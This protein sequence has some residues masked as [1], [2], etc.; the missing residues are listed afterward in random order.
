M[1]EERLV[2]N[3]KQRVILLRQYTGPE[4]RK[5]CLSFSRTAMVEI[6][7]KVGIVYIYQ[8]QIRFTILITLP[9][10]HVSNHSNFEHL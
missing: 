8:N 10:I 6:N 7:E 9:T 4:L 2:S 5:M 3:V 1:K